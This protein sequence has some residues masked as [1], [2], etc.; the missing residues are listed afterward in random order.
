MAKTYVK[1][2]VQTVPLVLHK[3]KGGEA[4]QE[5]QGPCNEVLSFSWLTADGVFL[6]LAVGAVK[7]KY[8]HLSCC[9]ICGYFSDEEA[10]TE[11]GQVTEKNH[12]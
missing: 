2:A 12:C 8:F 3:R 6:V 1:L 9:C 4:Q 5:H 7:V 10:C 11:H